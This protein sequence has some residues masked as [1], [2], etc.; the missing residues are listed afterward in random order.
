MKCKY[1]YFDWNVFKY[2]KDLD[3]DGKFKGAIEWLSA[4]YK[5]PFSYAHLCDRQRGNEK[6]IDDD[7]LFVDKI[8][9][10]FM[11]GVDEEND[12]YDISKRDIYSM[13]ATVK[14]D[15]ENL[16][17]NV[18]IG[19]DIKK[20]IIELGFEEYFRRNR[21]LDTLLKVILAALNRFDSDY[22]LYNMF[23]EYMIC[24]GERRGAD[25]GLMGIITKESFEEEDIE[26]LIVECE[27]INDKKYTSDCE[28]MML[29]FNLLEFK[30]K[31]G[32][33]RVYDK[34]SPKNNFT[35]ICTDSFHMVNAKF[36]D[37]FVSS[38]K[39]M[40]R[41]TELVYE[42]FGVNTIVVDIQTFLSQTVYGL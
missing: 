4:R 3:M 34:I 20:K 31:I 30:R 14:N 26:R 16:Y 2:I 24:Q 21:S 27:K 29:I 41:K 38:D 39:Q 13:Y 33:L 5:F 32:N 1:I 42:K 40:R 35:N 6:E 9:E 11:L 18:Q 25:S 15:K 36:S 22:N 8:S 10:G 19:S 37:C 12:E 28:K 23:R 17:P 7:L